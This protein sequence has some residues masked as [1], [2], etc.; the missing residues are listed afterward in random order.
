VLTAENPSLLITTGAPDD[1][2][3]A[4]EAA[5][6]APA[7]SI[8]GG[9]N[10]RPAPRLPTTRGMDEDM[11]IWNEAPG[12]ATPSPPLDEE[13]GEPIGRAALLPLL[14]PVA[15]GSASGSRLLGE[16]RCLT[17]AN[18]KK[19]SS[20]RVCGGTN[21]PSSRP[22]RRPSPL[23]SESEPD[24]ESEEYREEICAGGGTDAVPRVCKERP[25]P[26][27]CWDC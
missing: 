21:A 9:G 15:D 27:I 20:T 7:A 1:D 17:F 23:L 11:G 2:D 4:D 25:R 12:A 26:L 22:R 8:D 19:G 14:P 24:S 13:V 6:A 3:D 10:T 18:E 16:A 5:G